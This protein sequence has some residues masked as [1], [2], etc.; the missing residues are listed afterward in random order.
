MHWVGGP[1]PGTSGKQFKM[2]PENGPL[3]KEI[4]FGNYHFQVKLWGCIKAKKMGET[5]NTSHGFWIL[6]SMEEIDSKS[7]KTSRPQELWILGSNRKLLEQFFG[8]NKNDSLGP[9]GSM[10]DIFTYI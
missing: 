1:F 4:P 10:Y 9:I 7:L 5:W 3:E 6:P 2:E 8:P